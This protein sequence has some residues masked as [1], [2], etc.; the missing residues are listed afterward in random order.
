MLF[1]QTSC[2]IAERIDTD[3]R[4]VFTVYVNLMAAAISNSL[5][6]INTETEMEKRNETHFP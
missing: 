3:W 6:V 5:K 4:S 1:W 2:I